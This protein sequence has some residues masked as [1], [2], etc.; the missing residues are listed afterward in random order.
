MVDTHVLSIDGRLAI[1]VVPKGEGMNLLGLRA[2]I[3]AG[4]V[5]EAAI[6]DL[7]WPFHDA[8]AP[9][10]PFGRMFGAPVFVDPSLVSSTVIGFAVFGPNDFIEMPYDDFARL[11]QPRV[12]DLAG[13]GELPPPPLH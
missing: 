9:I 2:K 4:L 11:E 10:P 6:D 1:G 3:G 12:E 5:E 13:A 7:P 8:G